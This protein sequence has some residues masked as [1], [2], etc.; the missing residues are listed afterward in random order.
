[1]AALPDV[2]RVK[3]GL[4]AATLKPSYR[5]KGEEQTGCAALQRCMLLQE[6]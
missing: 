1:M 5:G 2:L 3:N 4:S 6:V